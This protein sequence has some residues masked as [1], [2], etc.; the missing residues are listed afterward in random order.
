M[1]RAVVLVDMDCFYVQVEQRLNPSLKGKPCAVVQYKKYRGGGRSLGGK[2]GLS[3]VE[4][5]G[6]EMMGDLRKFSLQHL[7][8][9]YGDKTGVQA[10][11]ETDSIR[12]RGFFAQRRENIMSKVKDS[13]FG[14]DGDSRVQIVS[15]RDLQDDSVSGDSRC[16]LGSG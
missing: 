12:E 15:V 16:G 6:V 3:L 11:E 2:L 5:L 10:L 1:D 9:G 4:E 13:H 8:T 7:Q 14:I